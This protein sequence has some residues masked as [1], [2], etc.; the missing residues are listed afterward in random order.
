VTAA[1][2]IACYR[3]SVAQ[4]AG[5]VFETM[6]GLSIDPVEGGGALPAGSLTAAVYYAGTWRGV[7]LLECSPEQ[8]A[9]WAARYMQLAPPL[10]IDDVRDGVGE[11]ANV[12]AGNLKALLPSGVGLSIPSVVQGSDYSVRIC[13]G[14]LVEHMSFASSGGA[15]RITLVEVVG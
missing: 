13:G 14:N 6:L 11:V 5:T 4:I 2:P 8:G 12:I 1:F 10:S 15:F 3:E 9:D 7:L